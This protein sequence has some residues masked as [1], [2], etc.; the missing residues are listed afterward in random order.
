MKVLRQSSFYFIIVSLQKNRPTSPGAGRFA[1]DISVYSL[2][3]FETILSGRCQSGRRQE[4]LLSAPDG[5]FGE[6]LSYRLSK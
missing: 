5:E 4:Y 1:F 2:S 6:D 3:F